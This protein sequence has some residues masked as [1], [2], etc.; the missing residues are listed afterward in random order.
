MKLNRTKAGKNAS[1]GNL[2]G[3]ARVRLELDRKSHLRNRLRIN[4]LT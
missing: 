3:V 1:A 2:N 4:H